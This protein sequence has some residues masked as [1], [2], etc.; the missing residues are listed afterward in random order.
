MNKTTV[1]VVEDEESYVEALT[2]GLKREGFDVEVARTG[3]DA[4]KMFGQVNP[5][6][7]LLDVMLPGLS[8][9]DVCRAIRSKSNTP[10]IMVTAKDSEVDIVLGLEMG[11]DDYI[12]KPYQLRELI[13]RMRSVIRRSKG[14]EPESVAEEIIEIGPIRLDLA[15][16]A[17]TVE[18]REISLPLKEYD[19]LEVLME[20]AGRAVG[21]SMLISTVW[22]SDYAGDTK[23]LD[24][25]IKRLRS[26]IE[27]DP[28]CPRYITTIPV[29]YTHLTLPTICSV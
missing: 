12:T 7:I 9:V 8:G 18:G 22:G 1:L 26:N 10:V 15:R 16:H 3:T 20:N 14:N 4:L 28:S 19:L 5:D 13:A 24:V 11:A 25:H 29:S 23:T 27:P 2:S 6:L 21:R 17:V